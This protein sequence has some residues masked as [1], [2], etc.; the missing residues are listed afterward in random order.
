MAQVGSQGSGGV[1][2]ILFAAKKERTYI[3]L[4][5]L[6]PFKWQIFA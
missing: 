1:I 4:L 3:F 6:T 2:F 5:S